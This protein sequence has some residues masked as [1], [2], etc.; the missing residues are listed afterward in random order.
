MKQDSFYNII[1]LIF[2]EQ[3]FFKRRA[4]LLAHPV[5]FITINRAS[6]MGLLWRSC[7]I[8]LS[9]QP[10]ISLVEMHWTQQELE[11]DLS[12]WESM[13]SGALEA[14]GSGGSCLRC[15]DGTGAAHGHEVP[16]SKDPSRI[17]AASESFDLLSFC[18]CPLPSV[19][20]WFSG[21]FQ[22]ESERVD[23]YT[24]G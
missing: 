4:S 21:F 16:F 10:S 15:F 22:Q 19:K 5:V 8:F 1:A 7:T 3:H 24:A 12:Q 20:R 6:F 17:S 23:E 9:L 2:R 13:S 11:N 14:W 18:K